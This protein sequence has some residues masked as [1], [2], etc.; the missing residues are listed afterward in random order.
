VIDCLQ[1]R[2]ETHQL[3][4]FGAHAGIDKLLK[5]IADGASHDSKE[6][7]PPP[8]CHPDTRR[9]VLDRI[10]EWIQDT[11]QRTRIF[12]L[13]GPAGAGKSAIAQTI[14]ERTDGK[15]LVSSF[16]FSRGNHERNSNE[17]LWT[18][19]AFHIST[20]IPDLRSIIGATVTNT[21]GIF[22]KNLDIQ[23]MKLIIEPLQSYKPQSHPFKF[24]VIIDGL[25]ECRGNS[26]PS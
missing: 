21:P 24:L 25:D 23:L 26:V 18:T 6:R 8:R 3:I 20:S 14:A 5:V 17:K 11:D 15:E 12:L 7:Y 4:W 22:G 13:H 16:F 2:S 1:N 10:D 19:L 9:A